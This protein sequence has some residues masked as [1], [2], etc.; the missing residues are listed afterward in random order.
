MFLY[1]LV[2][3]FSKLVEYIPPIYCVTFIVEVTLK[4]LLQLYNYNNHCVTCSEDHSY[5]VI[6]TTKLWI[7]TFY[8]F[9][10]EDEVV[11]VVN[12]LLYIHYLYSEHHILVVTVT[13]EI[14]A[15]Q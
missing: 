11:I 8:H 10:S 6:I 7:T 5:T 13:K 2:I 12:S 1:R 4:L 14:S 9:P 15:T 3:F